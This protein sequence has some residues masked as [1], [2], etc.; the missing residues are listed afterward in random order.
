MYMYVMYVHVA[1]GRSVNNF[2]LMACSST[3]E[4]TVIGTS[5]TQS[6]EEHPATFVDLPDDALRLIYSKLVA[7]AKDR[8]STLYGL[9]SGF[10]LLSRRLLALAPLVVEELEIGPTPAKPG[11]LGVSYVQTAHRRLRRLSFLM[12]HAWA[13]RLS[14][15]RALEITHLSWAAAARLLT[16]L[17]CWAQLQELELRFQYDHK[18]SLPM[19]AVTAQGQD[20]AD[21]LGSVL[22]LGCLPCLRYLWL[23]SLD[24]EHCFGQRYDPGNIAQ[25]G[26]L[27][28]DDSEILENLKPTAALWWMAERAA[29]V[30][31]SKLHQFEYE[32]DHGADVHA[33]VG[34]FAIVDWMRVRLGHQ[35]HSA[36]GHRAVRALLLRHGARPDPLSTPDVIVDLSAA[37]PPSDAELSPHELL[38]SSS[39]EADGSEH[40]DDDESAGSEI[41][42]LEEAEDDGDGGDSE[43]ESSDA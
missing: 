15:L 33:T 41:G 26:T 30:R 40:G 39:D 8:G 10:F 27:I 29:H 3:I 5:N 18:S 37:S 13:A 23:G 35:K 43:S 17:P 1:C 9:F 42:W 6:V 38:S 14:G 36:T 12:P 25:R 32:L 31:C 19:Q 4:A 22:K 2:S 11:Y 7:E 21:E 24:C 34:A 28:I 16:L 20:F